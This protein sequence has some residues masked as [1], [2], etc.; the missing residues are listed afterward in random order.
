MKI[1]ISYKKAL[2]KL[3]GAFVIFVVLFYFLNTCNMVSNRSLDSVMNTEW[4][5][6]NL[7]VYFYNEENGMIFDDETS[8]KF[9]YTQANGYIYAYPFESF[10]L[11]GE[12]VYP[13]Y[14]F[15]N[16]GER[17]YCSTINV[18]FYAESVVYG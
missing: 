9:V 14:E 4:Y 2:G 12:D 10:D 13:I 3:L 6:T 15:T 5:S 8:E 1:R 11:E 17:L 18:M 16:L 7:T